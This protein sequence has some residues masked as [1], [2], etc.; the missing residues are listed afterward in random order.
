MEVYNRDA[1]AMCNASNSHITIRR[2]SR[3]RWEPLQKC[4]S[5]QRPTDLDEAL[6]PIENSTN[7]LNQTRTNNHPSLEVC[8]K[9]LKRLLRETKNSPASRIDGIGWQELKIWFLLDPSGLCDMINLIETLPPELKQA[10]VVV[11]PK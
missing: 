5:L 4:H 6:Y 9:L 2:Q 8:P 11:T 3:G 10:R 1:P 7:N